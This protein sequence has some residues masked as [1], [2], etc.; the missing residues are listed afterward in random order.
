MAVQEDRMAGNTGTY[1]VSHR[2]K[3]QL[4]IEEDLEKLKIPVITYDKESTEKAAELASD[5]FFR[6]PAHRGGRNNFWL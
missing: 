6:S 1:I 3:D 2:Y 5:V 4:D